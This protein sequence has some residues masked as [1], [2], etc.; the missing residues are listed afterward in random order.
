MRKILFNIVYVILVIL[1]FIIGTI[2]II[3]KGPSSIASDMLVTTVMETS[4]LKFLAKTYFSEQEIKDIQER[5]SIIESGEITDTTFAFSD[6]N[7]NKDEIEI[8]DIAGSTYKGKMMIIN[9]PTR[10]E[11]AVLPYFQA[12]GYGKRVEDFV[13]ENDALAGINSGGFEDINGVGKG[14]QP[15]GLV[16]KDYKIINGN[17]STVDTLIG[18]DKDNKLV[19]GRM[20][21]KKAKELNIRDGVCFGPVFIVNGKAQQ[22]SGFSGGVNPR[23]VIGQRKDGAVLILVIDGRQAHSIGATYEDCIDVMLE[24]GA[25]TAA[26]L[27]GGSSSVMVYNNEIINSCASLYGSRRM[28]TAF[29]VRKN[30]TEVKS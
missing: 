9:D 19:V 28:P 4:A 17:E 2:T 26:N 12:G 7:L 29:I 30:E 23:T 5:N 18:F 11:L 3:F 27:D 6:T 25:Y 10:I 20:S 8:I 14:G 16:I 21:G 1:I 15:L 13:K 24:Y 22:V